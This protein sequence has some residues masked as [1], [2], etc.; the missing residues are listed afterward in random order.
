[1]IPGGVPAETGRFDPPG[2][3]PGLPFPGIGCRLG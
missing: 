2:L 3:W 1:M